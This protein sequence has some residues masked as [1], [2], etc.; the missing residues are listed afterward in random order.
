MAD[1]NKVNQGDQVRI[2]AVAFNGWQDAAVYT[3]LAQA[4]NL[5]GGPNPGVQRSPVVVLAQNVSGDTLAGLQAVI[6]TS[7]V[8]V[9]T[10]D[11]TK[12]EAIMK[13]DLPAD[14]NTLTW[15][16]LINGTADKAM[17]TVVT[18]GDVLC[19]INV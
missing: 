10:D 12:A 6:L 13:M 9:P 15:G 16:I 17:G 14:G 8:F 11:N 1:Y 4:S 18:M 7:P 5:R 19:K 2:P 3:R